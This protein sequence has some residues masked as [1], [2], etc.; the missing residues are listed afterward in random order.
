M[1]SFPKMSIASDFFF[2]LTPKINAPAYSYDAFESELLPV[3]KEVSSKQIDYSIAHTNSTPILPE[4]LQASNIPNIEN[5]NHGNISINSKFSKSSDRFKF[6]V[7]KKNKSM[8]SPL[9]PSS[10]RKFN[11]TR[12]P[13]NSSCTYSSEEND[14][15]DDDGIYISI[16]CTKP[17]IDNEII[18][19]L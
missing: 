6:T 14:V 10:S 12:I 17:R 19:L 7:I 8:P 9:S 18:S 11:I 5:H 13:K 2:D 4:N 3:P 16:D 15:P 1:N